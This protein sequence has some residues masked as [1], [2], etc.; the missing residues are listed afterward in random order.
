MKKYLLTIF[1]TEN[2]ADILE[3][4]ANSVSFVMKQ[5]DGFIVLGGDILILFQTDQNKSEL[6]DDLAEAINLDY[7]FT[8]TEINDEHTMD[9]PFNDFDEDIDEVDFEVMSTSF[10]INDD[11]TGNLKQLITDLGIK[12]VD[13]HKSKMNLDDILDKI[14]LKGM[15]SLSENELQFLKNQ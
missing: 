12:I 1:T 7:Y 4:I 10:P 15:S 14:N 9:L 3:N 6:F 5:L 2:D 11:D 13:D 8:L